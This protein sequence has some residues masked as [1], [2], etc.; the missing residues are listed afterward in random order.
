MSTGKAETAARRSISAREGAAKLGV[1]DRTV[2]RLVAE[3]RDNFETRARERR[4]RAAELRNSGW[5]YKQ[6]ADEM[7]CS[8]GAVGSLLH[9][10]RKD[11]LLGCR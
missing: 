10:A 5:S 4:Q 3:P 1:S 9:I 7:G 8:I 2:R 6:I 11:G